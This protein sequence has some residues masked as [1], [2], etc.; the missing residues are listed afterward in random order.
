MTEE[1]YEKL[2]ELIE[3]YCSGNHNAIRQAYKESKESFG[4]ASKESE[5]KSNV[6]K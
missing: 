1:Q 6:N 3:A 4:F 5:A 2:T